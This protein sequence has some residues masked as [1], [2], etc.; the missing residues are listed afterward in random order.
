[1]GNSECSKVKDLINVKRPK[2][3]KDDTQWVLKC[4]DII[5]TATKK[6]QFMDLE[7]LV[8]STL[9]MQMG[10]SIEENNSQLMTLWTTGLC[11]LEFVEVLCNAHIDKN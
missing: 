9:M 5:D 4:M 10:Q 1:M 7:D 2:E 8:T 3:L 11:G 6:T